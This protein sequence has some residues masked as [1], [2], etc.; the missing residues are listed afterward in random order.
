MKLMNRLFTC[1]ILSLVLA[2]CASHSENEKLIIGSWQGTQWLSGGKPSDYN[3]E[4]TSFSFNDK[5]EY[6]FDYGSK[7]EKGTYKIEHDMLFT[8]PAGE[9]EM[10]VRIDKLTKDS[11]VFNMNRGGE[12]ELLTL[13][14]K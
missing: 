3:V 10:M 12:E 8:T 9:T 4:Q 6:S 14:R 13:I 11:M 7:K 5:G 2:S 1:I